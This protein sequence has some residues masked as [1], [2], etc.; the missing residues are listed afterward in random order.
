MS[1]LRD[2]FAMRDVEDIRIRDRHEDRDHRNRREGNAVVLNAATGGAGP[3]RIKRMDSRITI[4]SV[5]L[6]ADDIDDLSVL[7]NFTS[8]IVLP[9]ES[10]VDLIF[11]VLRSRNGREPIRIGPTFTFSEE[12]EECE[13]E[14][15]GFQVFD[16]DL[17]GGTLTYTVVLTTNSVMEKKMVL[18]G[19]KE[20]TCGVS[21]INATLSAL[22]VEKE[23]R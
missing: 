21:I 15:F 4:V 3:L 5:T 8:I 10:S 17:E 23:R 19:M 1:N 18:E 11:E 7:L 16:S 6:D 12:T 14:S 22:G 9:E 2:P 13:S 20:K